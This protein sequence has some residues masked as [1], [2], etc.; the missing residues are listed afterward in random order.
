MCSSRAPS[1]LNLREPRQSPRG[2]IARCPTGRWS[3]CGRRRTGGTT[4]SRH[5]ADPSAPRSGARAAGPRRPSGPRRGVLPCTG[6]ASRPP[7]AVFVHGCSAA[8]TRGPATAG[9]GGD[10]VGREYAEPATAAGDTAPQ[11]GY[12]KPKV[13]QVALEVGALLL[14][15]NGPASAVSAARSSCTGTLAAAQSLLSA[16]PSERGRSWRGNGRRGSRPRIR[17]GCRSRPTDPSVSSTVAAAPV[18]PRGRPG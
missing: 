3:R 6:P 7:P 15:A 4:S 1:L 9:E 5:R 11:V 2:R 16:H 12:A 14:C 10:L 18:R 17:P 13:A 8:F